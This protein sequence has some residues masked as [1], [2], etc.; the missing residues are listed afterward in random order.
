MKADVFV[1]QVEVHE[2]PGV[3]PSP[4]KSFPLCRDIAFRGLREPRKRRAVD[5]YL[6]K[7]IREFL[8]GVGILTFTA[9]GF[10]L[11]IY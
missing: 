9:M 2:L 3:F 1:V 7:T 8:N 11:D 4:R 6:V 5:A 10:L